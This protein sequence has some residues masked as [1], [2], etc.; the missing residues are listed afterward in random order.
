[1]KKGTRQPV[2]SRGMT[3]R[4]VL[5][6]G[7]TVAAGAAVGP[8][9]HTPGHGQT[10]KNEAAK[11]KLEQK[12]VKIG[13]VYSIAIPF[14]NPCD[15]A[16]N[17]I[18]KELGIKVFIEKPPK[19]TV[20]EQIKIIENLITRGVNGLVICSVGEGIDTT[21]NK[22]V[23]SG[24]PVFMFAVDN[25]KSKRLA[26]FGTNQKDYAEKAAKYMANLIGGKGTVCGNG[27]VPTAPDQLER[28]KYFKAYI[29]ANYPIKVLDIQYGNN[30]PIRTLSN[31]E[32]MISTHKPNGFWAFNSMTGGTLAT[33]VKDIGKAKI[34]TLADN[35][36]PDIIKGVREGYLDATLTQAPYTMA[37]E[38]LKKMT[39]L[40][41][42][43]TKL[44][45]DM[46]FTDT[47]FITKNDIAK[48]FDDQN[49]IKDY[50]KS[51]LK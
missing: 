40:L 27:G 17:D 44:D 43:G 11:P 2:G 29:E 37:Y 21:I 50:I 7:A 35:D 45:R 1:M 48:Y 12:D 26:Y 39:D 30:D 28:A 49:K 23:E 9:V 34:K 25:V 33:V 36:Y 47:V 46:Y 10:V 6:L 13:L 51:E 38:A 19:A 8:F 18:T 16:A 24:I 41:V 20:D 4:D 22:A 3:R 5:R 32:G 31:I 14:F 42:K 15:A